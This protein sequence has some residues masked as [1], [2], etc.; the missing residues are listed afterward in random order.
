MPWE[1]QTS[2]I[3]L[4]L[5]N[6]LYQRWTPRKLIQSV[7]WNFDGFVNFLYANRAKVFINY[8]LKIEK[9]KKDTAVQPCQTIDLE[10]LMNQ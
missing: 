4:A 7:P 9:F 3:F 6:P 10:Y 8:F 5:L 1:L 2:I